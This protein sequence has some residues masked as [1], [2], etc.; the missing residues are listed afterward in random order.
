MSIEETINSLKENCSY[1]NNV[2]Y[3]DESHIIALVTCDYS[4]ED[5]R[6]VV[7]YINE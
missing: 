4:V 1:I 2:K 7:F 6:L 5:G 3:N